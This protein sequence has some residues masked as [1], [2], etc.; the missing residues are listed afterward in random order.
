M[1]EKKWNHEMDIIVVGS[2]AAGYCAAITAKANGAKVLMV[3]KAAQV[4]G[5]TIRSG[6]GFW[7]PNNRLQKEKGIID[8]KEDAIKYVAR[9]SYPHLYNSN[10]AQLGLPQREFELISTYYDN[11]SKMVDF[12]EQQG[13]FN[14]V[15]QFNWTGTLQIDYMES[16]PEN[17]GIR[18][19]V[20][21]SDNPEGQ[22]GYGSELIN[23]FKI[24]ADNHEIPL[25]LNHRVES[26]LRNH[27]GEV[28]GIE[29]ATTDGTV[30]LR[31]KQAVI[32]CSGGYTHNPALLLH[33]QYGP[34]FGG[35]AAPTN[36]G[37]FVFMSGEI[38]A[39]LGNMPG[40]FRSQI[41]LEQALQDPNGIH[42]M[43][44]VLGDSILEVNR[45]GKRV[46]DEKRNYSD[47]TM[48]HFVWDPVRGEWT[49]MLL[50]LI[51]DD[52]TA[53]LWWQNAGWLFSGGK[54]NTHV[55]DGAN[56]DELTQ[57]IVK[58]L[59]K[60]ES[61]T[62]GFR[63]DASF[64]ENLKQTV[65]KFNSFARN[66]VD[67]DFHRGDFAYDREWSTFPPTIQGE[68]WPPQGSKNYTMFPLSEKGPYHA[69]ILAPGTLDTN[70]GPIIDAQARILD[71]HEQPIPGLYGAGNCIAAP[72][73]NA[74][75]GG[76]AT[77][78]QAMVFGHIAGN[79]AV[80][81]PTKET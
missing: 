2:G 79:N 45:Y 15:P 43:F 63:L 41:A 26:I 73:A 12:L 4:G 44:F 25:L 24:W 61:S 81:E 66:G 74:Y 60:L 54:D 16:I 39:Q 34:L 55:I 10:D 40:A 56:L 52:R 58:R 57:N 68:K 51:Y 72:G 13:V 80:K 71:T 50:F 18:G 11:A 21:Y 67:E 37:D 77:L 14:I 78:G 31:V 23:H 30:S 28:I 46:M 59:A 47:R 75:W 6:G 32:F 38:G 53:R 36:T 48:V 8:S 62:G 42:T 76:G 27:N 20:L 49:N 9:L 3:E 64:T 17:K 22:L 7:I 69:V 29:A 19:R 35:C 5:T 1:N 65:T 70:G 33:F